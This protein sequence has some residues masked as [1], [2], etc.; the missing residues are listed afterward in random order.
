MATII[1]VESLMKVIWAKFLEDGVYIL[2]VLLMDCLLL[3][4]T[5]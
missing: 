4:I 1:G 5:P 3:I 2:T